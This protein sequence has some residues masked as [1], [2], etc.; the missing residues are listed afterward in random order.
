M[1][2]KTEAESSNITETSYPKADMPVAGMLA[3]SLC[4]ISVH[5]FVLV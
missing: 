3:F 5:L 1:E 4:Y 2:I